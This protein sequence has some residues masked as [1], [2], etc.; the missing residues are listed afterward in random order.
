MP[1]PVARRLDCTPQLRTVSLSGGRLES[2]LQA[3]FSKSMKHNSPMIWRSMTPADLDRVFAIAQVVHPDFP[4][5]RAVFANRL[6]LFG[7][8]CLCLE[9]SQGVVGYLISHPARQDSPPVLDSLWAKLPLD[10]DCYYIHDLALLP[11]C[12]GTGQGRQAMSLASDLA[13]QQGYHSMALIAV[14]NSA[15]FW[16]SCGFCAVRSD[17]LQAKL[18]SYGEG[19]QFMVRHIPEQ[20]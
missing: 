10:A 5:D 18:G 1:F 4:E 16:Q 20:R 8:G 11:A 6:E 19:S 15:P 14:G 3:T 12:R 9:G 13:L 2:K 17:S 7:A